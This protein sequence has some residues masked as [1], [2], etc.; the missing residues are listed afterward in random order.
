M[1]GRLSVRWTTVADGD[2]AVA[3]EPAVLAARRHAVAP[4]P[5]TWLHQ[6][7]GAE[8]VVV[9]EAGDGAGREAD[10]AVT[11]VPGAVVAVQTADCVPV[12]LVGE[13]PAGIGVGVAHAGWR[14]LAAGVIARTAEALAGLGTPAV[15]AACG[16]HIRARCYEFGGS[17][18]AE[19]ASRYG[20]SVVAT[21][22]WGTPALDVAA[23]VRAACSWSDLPL[24][25]AGT[26]T[27]CSP[28]HWS[29]RAR[30]EDG[31]QALVAWL[32]EDAR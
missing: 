22:A 4:H 17:D 28:V 15:A 16:P 8:V 6:V 7:H 23:A 19:V 10:A 5:W 30:A 9:T 20:P 14:G 2:L 12:L 24:A 32:S 3:T 18:L 11:V 25:D 26:C 21:T 29:Y 13:G 31:R 1:S 27:A